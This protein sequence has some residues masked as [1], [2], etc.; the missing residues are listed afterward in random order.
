[1]TKMQVGAERVYLAYTCIGMNS[2]WELE[3]DK[4]LEAEADTDGMEG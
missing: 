3:H 1:M 2:E 4:S